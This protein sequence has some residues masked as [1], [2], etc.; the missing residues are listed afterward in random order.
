MKRIGLLL[1]FL[2]TASVAHAADLVAVASGNF[3]SSSTWKV[4]NA[5]GNLIPNNTAAAALSTSNQD[6]STFT[7]GAITVSGV[8]LR[9]STRTQGSPTN[10]LT[11]TL[12]NSTDSLDVASV[13]I[14]VSDLPADN[15]TQIQGWFYM[16]FS[17]NQV[18]TAGKAYLIRVVLS[19]TSTSVALMTNGGTNWQ[20]ML[21]T[22][23]TQAPAAGDDLHIQQLLDG[24]SNP[25]SSNTITVTMN[26]T[27][28]TDYGSAST[29]SVVPALDISKG[30]ILTYGTTAA[31]NYVLRISG[32]LVVTR[33]GE[34][35]IGTT[36]TP[37]PRDSTA[38]LEFDSSGSNE[39]L[40][41]FEGTFIS[42]GQSRTS[43][44]T[45]YYA[46]L[47]TDEAAAQTVLGVDTDTGWL[48]GDEVVIASTSQTYSQSELRSL[49]G[50]AGASSITVSSGLT[51][52]HT[53]TAPAQGE[54][55]LITRNVIVRAVSS[56]QKA[57]V[58]FATGGQGTTAQTL[59][60][61]VDWT[62]FKWTGA[63]ARGGIDSR[64]VFGSGT[65]DIRD[66]VVHTPSY[67]GV[68]WIQ[69]NTTAAA[70]TWMRNVVYAAPQESWYCSRSNTMVYAQTMDGNIVIGGSTHGFRLNETRMT[71]INN[72][73]T[74]NNGKGIWFESQGLSPGVTDLV[75]DLTS[76]GNHAHSNS[77][78][79][80]TLYSYT[81]TNNWLTYGNTAQAQSTSWRN[82]ARGLDIRAYSRLR[83][84]KAFGNASVQVW[85]GTNSDDID[86][87]TAEVN[88]ETGYG[89]GDGF[90]FHV[91]QAWYPRITMRNITSGVASGTLTTLSESDIDVQCSYL[92][93]VTC[94]K[95]TLASATEVDGV[96]TGIGSGLGTVV[97]IQ[98]KDGTAGNDVTYTYY[99]TVAQTSTG[100]DAAPCQT[101]TPKTLFTTKRADTS[102]NQP[103]KGFLV[104]VDSGQ[105]VTVQ[106]Q[107]KKDAAYNGGQPRLVLKANP[108]V[109]ITADVVLDTMSVG[110]G[111]FETLTN[112]T[113]AVTADGV[114]EFVVECEGTAGFI[115]VDTWGIT[116]ASTYNG[117]LEHWYAG[118]P[119]D[120]QKRGRE[121]SGALD[122]W[123][124]GLPLY[125]DSDTFVVG[126]GSTPFSEF[127]PFMI[128]A[129]R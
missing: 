101:V 96:S 115:T 111:S 44:K 128:V 124:L 74:S 8:A 56:G 6:S 119:A 121:D 66:S 110:T 29:S 46:L 35:R 47:N 1:A 107:V 23:T 37:I 2:L 108:S 77:G 81:G 16:Q 32:W 106:V 112:T 97:R 65:V 120:G 64:A 25:A 100:C 91:C 18:L 73:A 61:D 92:A 12:R 48:S 53:G 104:P 109:G 86:I 82:N 127:S 90:G 116:G 24:S 125:L 15:L 31:T 62:Q 105:T 27:A 34:L 49:S 99:G 89:S 26:S 4:T 3:T 28:A 70:H 21:V 71:F 51:N 58:D 22:S 103:G 84:I 40:Y 83:N 36:G 5:T 38:V 52:A 87:D 55:V 72:R 95:C 129:L 9:L 117:E 57:R 13:T 93:D 118:L 126:P 76:Y 41:V 43:G 54:V 98:R 14:N 75:L 69:D 67:W 94:D 88:G 60:V 63:S 80:V 17:S 42:Q 7:P 113:A 20:R 33:Q 59:T 78:E 122:Y 79:G 123:T 11:M 114:L 39:G 68:Y 85:S 10:T 45:A 50:D 19:S 30:G 102:G